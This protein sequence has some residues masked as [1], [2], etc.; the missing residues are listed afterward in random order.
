MRA[1]HPAWNADNLNKLAKDETQ[2]NISGWLLLDQEHPEQIGHTRGT[3][4]EIHPI[5]KFLVCRKDHCDPN[6][7][8]DWSAL[9][10]TTKTAMGS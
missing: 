1:K 6:Q 8:S 2:V 9:D 7:E 10:D 4:W 5:T 3:L